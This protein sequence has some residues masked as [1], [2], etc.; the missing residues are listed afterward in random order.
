MRRIPLALAV[1]ISLSAAPPVH[2]SS[3][4]P[5][6][7]IVVL[8][9]G[10]GDPARIAAEHAGTHGAD[11][12]FI[13]RHALRGYAAVMAPTAVRALAADPRV[14]FISPD[15]PVRAS[16][17][18]SPATWGLDRSDQRALPLN[19]AYSYGTTGAGVKA[20][21]I[22]T[23][24]HVSHSEF[25]GR[26]SSG[27]D[28][29]DG[30][31][32]DDCHGHGT[33][34]SGT[35]GGSTYGIAKQVTLIAVR[36]L[37]CDGSGSSS[38]VVAGI[39]WVAGD[40][41]PGAPAVANMSLGTSNIS[42]DPARD[43]ATESAVS[44]A[45]ADGVTFA[46]AAGN[47]NEYTGAPRDA[48]NT[49]PAAVPAALT[50][51]AT[52]SNDQPASF[53]NYGTCVDLFAPGVSI[54]SSWYT[55]N[56]ATNTIS[57]TSMATPHVAGA[58]ALL[59][60]ASPSASPATIHAAIKS[61][62]TKNLVND[63][64]TPDNDL[65]FVDVGGTLGVSPG[66]LAFGDQRTGTTSV[67]RQ[68]TV[69]NTGTISVTIS[70]VT[71]GGTNPGDFTK[72]TDTCTG[73]SLAP[74]ATC[75]LAATFAPTATGSR[76]ASLSIASGAAGSP[77]VV[78]LTGT[79]TAPAI[80]VTPSSI[81]FGQQ[82]T[83]TTSAARAVTVTNTGT[84]P[85]AIGTATLAGA[86]AADFA[87]ATDACSGQTI[88]PSATCAF[89]LTFTPGGN[90][91][92]TGALSIPSDAGAPGSVALSGSGVTPTPAITV[93]PSSIAFGDRPVSTTSAPRQ[94]TISSTGTA[95]LQIGTLSVAGG[96]AFA[97]AT[98]PCS[99]ATLASG[100]SC[101]ISVTFAP[102]ATG[103]Q[104]AQVSVPTNAP[105]TPT[106][107]SLSGNGV[108]AAPEVSMAPSVLSFPAR[109]VG[110]TGAPQQV[111]VTNIGSAPLVV[112]ALSTSGAAAA[113]FARTADTCSGQTVAPSA[114]CAF[115]M[116]FTPSTYGTRS[117]SALFPSNATF[118][119]SSAGLS[120]TGLGAAVQVTPSALAFGDQ[121]VGSTASA[122]TVS[123]KNIGNATLALGTPAFSGAHASDFA[124]AA[125]GCAGVSLAPNA[126]CTV[127]IMFS[128]SGTGARTGAVTYPSNA[129]GAAASVALSGTGLGDVSAPFSRWTTRNLD[130]R[131]GGVMTVSGVATDDMAGIER[132]TVTFT[133]QVGAPTVMTATLGC[134]A[135]TQCGFTAPIPVTPG[136]YRITAVARDLAGN[137]ESPGAQ[138]QI[139]V[140]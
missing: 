130:A 139:V 11:I 123:V 97:L 67:A 42:G 75:A 59:L 102:T 8:R 119:P 74:A 68:V 92:R 101:V 23:G 89:S 48:C 107:V 38:G 131:V 69:T 60:Q 99:G 63:P 16:A 125:D 57:G 121:V 10:A 5:S 104:N 106:T 85:L 91:A 61:A 136:L 32:A 134:S 81:A 140:V 45:I 20:Y 82:G 40:H 41:Q 90:G 19:N 47:G 62:T 122:R 118:G 28:A 120:G 52:S 114:T 70:A 33:H 80:S 98:N 44:G 133:P 115:S 96:G 76:S 116:T 73:A 14:A 34:V 83:G 127:G 37:D 35:V 50:V 17:T 138:I 46:V 113:D 6:G 29:V 128:P 24:I 30:G 39:D 51:A 111:T 64:S 22:D 132:V 95:P 66:S 88:A 26:A 105:V 21:I 36:V 58:A 78:A 84:A 100:T 43:P 31:A 54:T 79:G 87:A 72:S 56:T 55:S 9:D 103:A 27:F 15:L 13:Y 112:G 1:L 110:T 49:S 7:V 117:A 94:V 65:L 71:L 2:A 53:S 3:A 4:L 18:Q 137:T 135:P 77:H 93:S 108:A 129:I 25:G 12:R 126:M 124:R 109:T 86:N